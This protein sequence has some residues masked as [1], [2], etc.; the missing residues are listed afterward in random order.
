[1]PQ[2]YNLINA[3]IITVDYEHPKAQS[4]TIKDGKIVCIDNPQPQIE[5]IDLKGATLIPGFIDSHFHLKNFGKRL[6]QLQLKG[7][8]SPNK[9]TQLVIEKSTERPIN[10]VHH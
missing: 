1:M 10:G 7:R 3:N 8:N 6:D 9:I 4:I 5:T 2:H